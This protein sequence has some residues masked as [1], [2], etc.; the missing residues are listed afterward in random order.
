MR[1]GCLQFAPRVGD[2]NN[3]LNRADAVLAK[4]NPDDLDTLDVL[5]LPEL[6]FTGYNFESLQHISPYLEPSG[7]GISSLWAR[8]TALKYNTNVIVGYPERVDVSPIWPTGP[9]YYNSAII[10][11]GDGETVANYRKSSLYSVDES[12]AL[13]GQDG[14][15]KRHV[16]GL[17]QTALGIGMDLNPYKFEAPWND[18][19]FGLHILEIRAHLVIVTMAWLT[20]EDKRD[21]SRMPAE[22]DMETLTYWIQRLEPVIRAEDEEEVIVVFCN[23]TGSEDD[24]VY[25]GTSAVVGIKDGEVHVYGLL[26]R[27]T[28]EV[29]VV[30]TDD[31]PFA[32]LVHRPEDET[33]G[34][35]SQVD[36][37]RPLGAAKTEVT[38]P[39]EAEPAT[40][41]SQVVSQRSPQEVSKERRR[42]KRPVTRLDIPEQRYQRTTSTSHTT[43]IAESPLIPTPTAPSPT[44]LSARPNFVVSDNR[45]S[46]GH[47]DTPNSQGDGI[48]VKRPVIGGSASKPSDT[49][50][51]DTPISD[52]PLSSYSDLE[53]L[54]E[55]YFWPSSDIPLEIPMEAPLRTPTR[56]LLFP[57]FPAPPESPTV[58]SSLVRCVNSD[59]R[60]RAVAPR[61][62]RSS[63]AKP[64]RSSSPWRSR[65]PRDGEIAVPARPATTNDHTPMRP[66]S[67]KSRNA[68]RSGRHEQ[69]GYEAEDPDIAVMAERLETLRRQTQSATAQR[70]DRNETP[71][72]GRPK[73][74]KSRN[75]SRSGRPSD[76]DFS[77]MERDLYRYHGSI[78]M[79]VSDS[80]LGSEI[81]RPLSDILAR[82]QSLAFGGSAQ[83]A[84]DTCHRSQV[85]HHLKSIHTSGAHVEPA[86]SRTM[87]WSEISRMVGEHMGR[88]DSQED[89]RGRQR[90]ASVAPIQ[91]NQGKREALTKVRAASTQ[92]RPESGGAI[93]SVREPSMGAPA[94]P[95]DEIVAEIIFRRPGFP[96]QTSRSNS[97]GAGTPDRPASGRASRRDS[98]RPGPD[99]KPVQGKKASSTLG[100]DGDE[101][102]VASETQREC[103]LTC[104][105]PSAPLAPQVTGEGPSETSLP[106][107]S[108]SSVQTLNSDKTSPLTPSPRYFEPRTPKAMVLPPEYRALLSMASDPLSS[109]MFEATNALIGEQTVSQFK[110]APQQ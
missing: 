62:K 90:S 110:K 36:E 1:I 94:D 59:D 67:P 19:E 29:L 20:R 7:S 58:P 96:T 73:S 77:F 107:L 39:R 16:R 47:V 57:A 28:K 41:A 35:V 100:K 66:A 25:A 43:P 102:L 75:A 50:I 21:F 55:K 53:H 89:T 33:A 52:T 45:P 92:T 85:E 81:L 63:S 70:Q 49:P 14:F 87:L 6:A 26:G 12:W 46:A 44:P 17:G 105:P 22:P 23:R 40:R 51:G 68:S 98:S 71:A 79:G 37:D 32:K 99:D 78:S 74:P 72:D 38:E 9:E 88:P 91:T 24:A 8:T 42:K 27:G 30:D 11:N 106:D 34:T 83:S 84:S 103:N 31:R 48:A 104:L 15:F 80:V 5:V 65:Q 76:M 109:S 13:E 93:R 101:P 54:S 82:G 4:A 69:H 10:V 64:E 108:G 18:F 2:I 3:N 60:P 61:S 56:G 86:E 95:D 97:R